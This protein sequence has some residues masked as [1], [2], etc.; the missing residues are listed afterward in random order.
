MLPGGM[1][2]KQMKKM[3]KKM[4]IKTDEID[5]EQVI[6]KCVDRDIIIDNPS[7][8][9]TVIQGQ[10]MFQVQGDVREAAAEED[11]EISQEDVDMVKSQ[12]G[13]SDEKAIAAL[14]KSGGDLAQAI[15]DLQK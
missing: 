8:V 14:E 9:K 15:L 2:P 1:N 5:A 11:V 13:A 10:E 4:G 12:T 7:V 3:M 6:I